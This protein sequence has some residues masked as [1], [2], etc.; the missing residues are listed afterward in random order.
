[1]RPVT[2]RSPTLQPATVDDI[3]W[4]PTVIGA[5]LGSLLAW[6]GGFL[7]FIIQMLSVLI[8]E[9][10]HALSAWLVGRPAIPKFDL[11]FGGGI[12]PIAA[13]RSGLLCVLLAIAGAW[14]IRSAWQRGPRWGAAA[15]AAVAIPLLLIVTGWDMP[16]F[17][18]AGHVAESVMAV[19]FLV[20]AATGIGIAHRLE[21]GVSALVGSAL[22]WGVIGFC[23]KLMNDSGFRAEYAEGKG[24][25]LPHDLTTLSDQLGGTVIGWAWA[26]LIFAILAVAAGGVV[27]WAVVQHRRR[28]ATGYPSL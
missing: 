13:Q 26:L 1:M 16:V 8:H 6:W 17:S 3:A 27:V 9:T 28:Q 12:T 11:Q 23:R 18:A 4:R 19:V 20:R 15:V 5:L 25:A 22:W 10:G 24:G 21:A 2:V 7:F 14:L